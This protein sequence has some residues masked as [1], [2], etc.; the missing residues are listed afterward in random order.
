MIGTVYPKKNHRDVGSKNERERR[1]VELR[2]WE[3]SL[4]LVVALFFAGLIFRVEAQRC[5]TTKTA[6]P[7]LD[8]AVHPA[9]AISVTCYIHH[10][11]SPQPAALT[12]SSHHSVGRL[13]EGVPAKAL[14]GSLDGVLRGQ[15]A[16]PRARNDA[17]HSPHSYAGLLCRC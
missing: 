15:V 6:R 1:F 12:P 7:S 9:A 8:A 3:E 14:E 11:A 13:L 5:P 2:N 10:M 16:G 4:S 17:L